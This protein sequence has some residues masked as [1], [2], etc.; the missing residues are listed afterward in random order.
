MQKY[1]YKD[2]KTGQKIQ[3]SKKLSAKQ[4]ILIMAVGDTQMKGSNIIRK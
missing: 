1:L 3:S 2:R 4:Y